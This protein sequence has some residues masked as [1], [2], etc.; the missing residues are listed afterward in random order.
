MQ[1]R[2]VIKPHAVIDVQRGRVVPGAWVRV[3]GGTILDW[4]PAAAYGRGDDAAQAIELPGCHLLPGLINSHAHLCLPS[5][6]IPFHQLQDDHQAL[7]TAI[8]NAAS[9]LA[10][11]VTTLRDCGDQ[12]GVLFGLR[13]MIRAA[14]V[15]GPR[16]VLCGAPLT[17][18]GGHA[19]FLGGVADGPAALRRAVAERIAAG[20]DFIKLIA[21]GGSTPGTRPDQASYTVAELE[22]AVRAA[23]RNGLRV[24]AHCRG[25]PGIRRAVAAGV[26]QIEHA[27]FERSNGALRFE[28][29]LARRMADAG[30]RVTPTIQ[31]YRDAL[32]R[33]QRKAAAQ[34]LTAAEHLRLASLPSVIAAKERGLREWL[35]AGVVCVAGND[36]GL[37][38][39]GFG[40]FWQELQAMV[41]AG[42]TPMQALVAATRSAAEALGLDGQLGIIRAGMRADLVAVAGDPTQQVADLQHVRLVMRNGELLSPGPRGRISAAA[43]PA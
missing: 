27:C 42:M 9:E 13:R 17:S 15:P 12:H 33:L 1:R 2:W 32:T 35:A 43:V 18:S 26:D 19:H 23:H 36:A 10:S 40:A 8:R 4:G 28:P 34:P 3:E 22:A 31:L 5:N 41:A 38:Q 20:A 24:T 29:Q 39:T 21:T 14:Q 30:I 11:G 16:L 25:T 7:R 37:P 6:G